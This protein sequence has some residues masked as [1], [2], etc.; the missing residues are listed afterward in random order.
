MIGYTRAE[1]PLWAIW[2]PVRARAMVKAGAT[3]FMAGP[4]DVFNEKDPYAG[5][6]GRAGAKLVAISADDGKRIAGLNLPAPPAFD[7]MVATPG[8]I[9]IALTDGSLV[10]LAGPQ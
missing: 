3:L 1:P 8:R 9:L 4:P 6:E 10:C 7:G 5:F 2:Q